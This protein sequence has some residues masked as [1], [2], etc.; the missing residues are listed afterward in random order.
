MKPPKL[1]RSALAEKKARIEVVR[2]RE[3]ARLIRLARAAG[4]FER[5]VLSKDLTAMFKTFVAKRPPKHSQLKRLTDEVKRMTANKSAQ[6][7]RDDTRR[8]ILLG[9]F[10]I[11]QFEHNP[12]LLA[13]MQG[14]IIRFLD[15]HKDPKVAQTN[16]ILLRQWCGISVADDP[17]SDDPATQEK[18]T[19][20]E[21]K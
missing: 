21:S 4:V 10:L 5:H 17:A 2:P 14:E 3:E 6:D 11:A 18:D 8:K 15:Q 19:S 13:Q 20:D 7:R 9:S 12:K 16:K 1:S